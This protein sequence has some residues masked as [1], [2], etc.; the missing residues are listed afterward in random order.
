VGGMITSPLAILFLIPVLASYWLPP[1]DETT[2]G[3]SK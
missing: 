3:T 1:K 2:S